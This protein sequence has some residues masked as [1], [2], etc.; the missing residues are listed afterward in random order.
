MNFIKALADEEIKISMD[1]RGAWGDNFFVE[2]FWGTIKYA[3]VY[4]RA[5]GNVAEARASLWR[6]IGFYNARRPHS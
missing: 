6:Y 1:G 2:R 5:C 4:L 3:E